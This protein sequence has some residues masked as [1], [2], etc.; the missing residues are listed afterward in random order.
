M[1]IADIHVDS[2]GHWRG[3]HLPE[4]APGATVI[5]GPNEAGKS[6]L[7]QLIRAILYGYTVRGH[8]RFVPPRYEGRVGGQLT[9]AAPQGRFEIRRHLPPLGRKEDFDQSELSVR[10]LDSSLQGRH[11]LSML[12]AGVD[13]SIFH[14]AFAV[15]LSE[16]QHLGTLSDTEA[17]RQLYGLA[18]GGDRVSTAEVSAQLGQARERLLTD[19]P[20][21]LATLQ[22]QQQ[23][24]HQE[25]SAQ[26]AWNQ[27]WYR[28]REQREEISAEIAQL[29]QRQRQFGEMVSGAQPSQVVREH[30]QE[31]R[32]LHG[33]LRSL[34]K[35]PN[36]PAATVQRLTRLAEQIREHRG[37]WEALRQR[38]RKLRGQANKLAVHPPLLA[39]A[40]DIEALHK[41]RSRITALAQQ[42]T[43]DRKQAEELELELQGEMER[44]GIKTDWRMDSLP[45]MTDDM[46]ISLRDPAQ[47]LRSARE[48][49]ETTQ[50]QEQESQKESQRLQQQLESRLQSQGQANLTATIG[51]LQRQAD[52]LRRRIELDQRS[53]RLDRKLKET[54]KESLH[55]IR[56]QVP[57]W[58]GLMVLGGVFTLGVVVV[59]VAL[60]GARFGVADDR[61]GMMALLGGAITLAS[62]AMKNLSEF[63]AGRNLAVCRD[64]LESLQ[65]QRQT[66]K[67]EREELNRQLPPSNEPLLGRLQQTQETLDGLLELQPLAEQQRVAQEHAQ[68]LQL[69]QQQALEQLQ[70]AEQ[71]WRDGLR[72]HELPDSIT[73][74]QFAQLSA[75]HSPLD[76]LRTRLL[77]LRQDLKQKQ[78]EWQALKQQVEQLCEQAELIPESESLEKQLDEL[79]KALKDARQNQTQRDA[80][81]RQWR[82][83]G[84]DQDEV[85]KTAKELRE[86]R[87]RVLRKYGI[88]DTKQ[89]KRTLARRGKALELQRQRDTSL[90]QL[91]GRLGECLT[92]DELQ[93][94]LENGDFETRLQRLEG[95]QQQVAARLASLHERRG[96]L[97]QQ[98][99]SMADDRSAAARRLAL[100]ETRRRLDA[101]SRTWSVLAGVSLALDAVRAAY[102]SDRQPETL[103]EASAYLKRLTGG[104]YPRIWTP[105]GESALCV[106]DQQGQSRRVEALSRG[107]REQV[108]L[109]LRLALASAYSRRGAGLPLILDDVFVN[110]DAQRARAAAQTVCDFAAAGHQ[111]LVFT[112]HDHIRDVFRSLG[113]DIRCLPAPEEVA[114]SG[115]PV[116]PEPLDRHPLPPEPPVAPPAPAP[117]PD[118]VPE[119][120]RVVSPPV[121]SANDPELDF[122]LLYGAPEYDPG[123]EP[124]PTAPV[125][126]AVSDA[127][128]ADEAYLAGYRDGLRE[129]G[130][131][132]AWDQPLRPAE[133][134]PAYPPRESY[135]EYDH[136]SPLEAPPWRPTWRRSFAG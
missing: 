115:R 128:G 73:P 54:R 83:I 30:W 76:R 66:T 85:A 49:V 41:R 93:Q 99:K 38:R 111:V 15:G 35:L 86:N 136:R 121:P 4:L 101:G 106:D 20:D 90:Q 95:E 53:V 11:L 10:S 50:R 131:W 3:L 123:Y 44:L 84:R 61:R 19:G 102:E 17:A 27:R 16:M 34:G 89:L 9:V 42:M 113:V 118:V 29:E 109:S 14:N 119:P 98:L 23:R 45:L 100:T 47:Q 72:A 40:S 122:E 59:L 39:R 127:D 108:Y 12:L 65:T 104:R 82:Q 22:Q 92:L 63:A 125:P 70:Q 79:L 77:T 26:D 1:K 64:E 74:A 24:L 114:E 132:P 68:T 48:R 103:A 36:I 75:A 51:R 57:P 133:P 37:S 105:F 33:G 81:Y 129:S 62:V 2:F 69:Q 67:H 8:Q 87:A 55:W 134:A 32:R 120:P 88:S 124:F 126:A 80:L 110:F 6:T 13:E 43:Q 21:G 5:H 94:E 116:L 18:S 107:T 96:E 135:A 28:L 130:T 71:R 7:L 46:V 60:F 25:L 97:S 78:A 112:C 52:L 56:R 31:C 91:A 117:V 58:R